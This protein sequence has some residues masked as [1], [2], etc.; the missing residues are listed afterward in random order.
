MVQYVEVHR[1]NAKGSRLAAKTKS[2][3]FPGRQEKAPGEVTCSSA[4]AALSFVQRGHRW[5]R[6][7]SQRAARTKAGKPKNTVHSDN[8]TTLVN[9]TEN[10]YFTRYKNLNI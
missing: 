10:A 9:I 6:A 8:S 2:S 7:A 5:N 1:H 4:H 3:E